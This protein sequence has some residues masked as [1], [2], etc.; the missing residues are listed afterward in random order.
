[1][2][3][4]NQSCWGWN[5]AWSPAWGTEREIHSCTH[6]SINMLTALLSCLFVSLFFCF[7][8]PVCLPD[9]QSLKTCPPPSI[10]PSLQ[11]TPHWRL[12]FS[13]FK[14]L[15]NWHFVGRGK[16]SPE[17]TPLTIPRH[18]HV[19]ASLHKKIHEFYCSVSLLLLY[20]SH[21][22]NSPWGSN[23]IHTILH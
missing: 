20:D 23:N 3:H 6:E 14:S 4:I 8:L 1:M 16:A 13:P 12:H 17:C 9:C 18:V 21:G 15:P 11:H 5:T 7:L 19:N 22:V 10:A 2:S